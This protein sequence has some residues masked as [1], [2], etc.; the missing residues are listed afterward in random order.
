MTPQL[1]SASTP[2]WAVVTSGENGT[3]TD[4]DA[5]LPQFMPRK[6]CQRL[7]SLIPLNLLRPTTCPRESRILSLILLARSSWGRVSRIVSQDETSLNPR[8]RCR[9]CALGHQ[10]R[11]CLR[12]SSP[13][14]LHQ[15]HKATIGGSRCHM[16]REGPIEVWHKPRTG[17]KSQRGGDVR[18]RCHPVKHQSV[19]IVG[20][21]YCILPSTLK[22]RARKIFSH[23]LVLHG[24]LPLPSGLLEDR[25]R[26]A[27]RSFP[28]RL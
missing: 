19:F 11:C 17:L 13:C 7:E 1:E 24:S 26:P 18:S 25:K 3:S 4:S 22:A 23:Q 12:C 21:Y 8:H 9:G 5:K 14:S 28:S 2:R 6:R 16:D 15:P 10:S 27:P 20:R